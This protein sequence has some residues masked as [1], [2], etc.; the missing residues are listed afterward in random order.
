MRSW[1]SFTI[2]IYDFMVSQYDAGIS[3][4]FFKIRIH[5]SSALIIKLDNPKEIYLV[6]A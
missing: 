3:L 4:V 2:I 5:V 6:K 1:L